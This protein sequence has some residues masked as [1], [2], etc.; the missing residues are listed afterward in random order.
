MAISITYQY[1]SNS[2]ASF[3][4]L[5]QIF[6][7]KS[8]ESNVIIINAFTSKYLRGYSFSTMY[9]LEIPISGGISN[10]VILNKDQWYDVDLKWS[11][12]DNYES[13]TCLIHINNQLISTSVLSSVEWLV[14][15]E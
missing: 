1:H 6:I 7:K 15:F 4:N 13:D 8:V 9:I 2:S 5:G 12:T 10:E 14:G 3:L 11:G